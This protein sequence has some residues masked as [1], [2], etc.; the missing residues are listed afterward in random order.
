MSH[1]AYEWV[2]S[3]III[4]FA[5]EWFMSHINGSCQSPVHENGFWMTKVCRW[6]EI[7]VTQRFRKNMQMFSVPVRLF[8]LIFHP[9][10][11]DPLDFSAETRR[12]CRN[13]AEKIERVGR[14]RL[15][16]IKKLSNLYWKPLY[17]FSKP[18]Y[19]EGFP[20]LANLRHS[21]PILMDQT[22]SHVNESWHIWT[23]HV[24][25]EWVKTYMNEARYIWMSHVCTSE[26]CFIWMRNVTYQ[27]NMQTH[28]WVMP[29][30][31]WSCYI[32]MRHTACE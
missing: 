29:Q 17:F 4:H 9:T 22:L 12:W 5:H 30:I 1:V 32:W 14:S 8:L 31:N 25:Y 19:D 24:E 11:S 2:V 15:E 18:L 21:K 26:S 13:P 28:E 7:S 16:M 10:S 3:H 27:W 20:P 6:G 23:S